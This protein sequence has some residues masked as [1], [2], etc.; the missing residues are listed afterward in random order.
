VWTARYD[1][2][3]AS[4][5][6]A[7]ALVVDDDG[8]VCVTGESFGLNTSN[9]YATIKYSSTGTQEWVSR[10]NG[11]DNLSDEA[12]AITFD[13]IGNVYVTG[14]SYA[15]APYTP[16]FDYLTVKYDA[17]GS[18]QWTAR[19][20]GTGHTQDEAHAIAVDSDGYVY[21][22]GESTGT[23]SYEDVVTI[24]YGE[25]AI[26]ENTGWEIYNTTYNL[27]VSPNPFN[28]YTK[29]RYSILDSG[30]L[31]QNPSLAIFDASGRLVRFLDPV[32]SIE[33]Q[34][35]EVFWDGTD[36]SNRRLPSGVYFLRL[37]SGD[38][39]ITQHLILVK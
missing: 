37:K 30:Y 17:L 5:D 9:D 1:G 4:D 36:Q 27:T 20:D 11:S 19:Y 33:G 26:T 35:S 28:Q 10:Y 32:S 38:R 18:E 21:I 24:C 3:G 12:N 2:P 7:L 31:M 15:N 25:D 8:N 13:D 29:I 22:T 14:R 23:T 6:E 39:Q 16:E 34:E